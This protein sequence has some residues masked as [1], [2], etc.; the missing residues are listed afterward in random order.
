V[1]AAFACASTGCVAPRFVPRIHAFMMSTRR[2]LRGRLAMLV[3][4]LTSLHASLPV[5][6]RSYNVSTTR[7]GNPTAQGSV[8]GSRSK[9]A[10]AEPERG[11]LILIPNKRRRDACTASF[12]M[13]KSVVT[14]PFMLLL[15][16]VTVLWHW[17]LQHFL[18]R[19]T[20][21]EF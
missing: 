12:A 6:V 3:R 16:T 18:D 14:S 10:G 1:R 5:I 15:C 4:E 20:I 2:C 7:G 8:S 11:I 19:I 13:S 9:R 17:L 21:S